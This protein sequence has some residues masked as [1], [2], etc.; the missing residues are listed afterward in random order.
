MTWETNG[1]QVLPPIFGLWPGRNDGGTPVF[2]PHAWLVDWNSARVERCGRGDI[3]R[4]EDAQN[5]GRDR[6]LTICW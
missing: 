2:P 1:S 6:S 3:D 4:F 5:A